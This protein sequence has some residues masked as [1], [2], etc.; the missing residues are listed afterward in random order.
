VP[1]VHGAATSVPCP[2]PEPLAE[3]EV[4]KLIAS[5]PPTSAMYPVTVTVPLAPRATFCGVS[6]CRNPGVTVIVAV[7]VTLEL[8]VDVAVTVTCMLSAVRYE[9]GVYAP[10]ELM[11]PAFE[12]VSPPLTLQVTLAGAPLDV[13][14]LNC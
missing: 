6:G 4:A 12:Y 7:A 1:R 2:S 13:T 5:V 14:A 11:V 3:L 10:L 9:G 8:A